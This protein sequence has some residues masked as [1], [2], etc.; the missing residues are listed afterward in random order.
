MFNTDNYACYDSK[1]VN[2]NV[3]ILNFNYEIFH[4]TMV[5][6][7]SKKDLKKKVCMPIE[8]MH[9]AQKVYSINI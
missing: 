2:V 4:N 8:F 1:K 6:C 3:L 5:I 7:Y 9:T